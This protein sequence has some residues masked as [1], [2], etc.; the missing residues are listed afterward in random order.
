MTTS[1]LRTDDLTAAVRENL[2]HLKPPVREV[3]A[4]FVT[5][6]SCVSASVTGA[7]RNLAEKIDN[8]VFREWCQTLIACQ[9]DHTLKDTLMP[10]VEKLGDIRRVQGEVK[11]I[12]FA[13][14][15]EYLIMACMV[16]GNLPLLYLLNKDWY[17]ALMHT[18]P[19]KITLA[20]CGAAILI[21]GLRMLKITKPM[22]YGR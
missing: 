9:N 16:V 3:F 6:T 2:P 11:G 18:V 19:G 13:A 4:A 21:T 17:A 12:L 14:R 10:T 7:I 15:M 5:E 1:Y 8:T 22:E 20:V